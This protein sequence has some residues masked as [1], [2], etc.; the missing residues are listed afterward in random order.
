MP[1][2]CQGRSFPLRACACA[3]GLSRKLVVPRCRSFPIREGRALAAHTA[4][5]PM[6]VS[7]GRAA[8]AVV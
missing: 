2:T 3:S 5:R 6:P 8:V 7:L 1:R 4:A